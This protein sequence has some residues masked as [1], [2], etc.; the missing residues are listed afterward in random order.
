MRVVTMLAASLKVV[1]RDEGLEE[2]HAL[3][4]VVHLQPDLVP[5]T[6]PLVMVK[7]PLAVPLA[8]CG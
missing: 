1:D 3:V 7:K 4:G 6:W 8:D 5:A 2:Q